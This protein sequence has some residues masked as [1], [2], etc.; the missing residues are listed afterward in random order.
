[1]QTVEISD[2]TAQQLHDLAVQERLS[3]SKLIQ[4]LV[5]KYR[6]EFVN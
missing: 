4:R 3:G 6:D 5:K 1:M 2:Q